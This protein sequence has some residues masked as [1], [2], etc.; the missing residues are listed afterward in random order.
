MPQESIKRLER[1]EQKRLEAEG[2]PS[3]FP[4]EPESYIV[5]DTGGL[6]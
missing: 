1:Q 4:E 3:L 5:R 6:P 2:R